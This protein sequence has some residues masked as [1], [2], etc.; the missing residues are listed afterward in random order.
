MR[1]DPTAAA[2]PVGVAGRMTRLHRIDKAA[3]RA[4][5]ATRGPVSSLPRG[6]AELLK[7]GDQA[8]STARPRPLDP[9]SSIGINVGTRAVPPR[10][11]SA[12]RVCLG[13]ADGTARNSTTRRVS[14]CN[15]WWPTEDG[16]NP[17]GSGH[18]HCPGLVTT[19]PF[20]ATYHSASLAA[21]VGGGSPGRGPR[22]HARACQ[23]STMFPEGQRRSAVRAR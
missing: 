1:L 14:W 17:R 5:S 7:G 4:S 21:L 18:P 15:V 20:R 13:G 11:T 9:Q 10:H 23:C 19:P 16:G 3:S 6:Q 22:D 8:G 2:H 12:G